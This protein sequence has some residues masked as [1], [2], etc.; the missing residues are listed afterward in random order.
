MSRWLDTILCERNTAV[1]WERIFAGL[2]DLAINTVSPVDLHKETV[3]PDRLLAESAWELWFSFQKNAQTTAGVLS[4]WWNDQS[5]SSNKAVL[6]LDAMSLRELASLLAGAQVRGIE[7]SNVSVTGS[8]VPSDTDSFAKAL[9][10]NSRG[11]LRNDSSPDSLELKGNIY[12][13]VV[14]LP[15]ADCAG[16]IPAVNNLLIWHTWLDD[17]IHVHNRLPDQIYRAASEILQ[18]NDFWEFVNRLRQGR[19]LVITSD[20]GYAV[21]RQFSTAVNE[22]DAIEALRNVFG[23]SRYAPNT[24][25]WNYQLM[26]PRVLKTN[27]HLVIIGQT[28]WKVQGGFPHICHGG[29]SLL[30]VAVP[31]VEFPAI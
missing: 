7:I 10:V 6:I 27:G 23:A 1:A 3:E 29:L 21:G 24:G 30:E 18:G 15:F 14:G 9:G 22:A 16:N 31:F 26:P 8:E 28:K 12:T 13:D 25:Q 20:H 19:A 11:R 5:S 4:N 2:K 17:L